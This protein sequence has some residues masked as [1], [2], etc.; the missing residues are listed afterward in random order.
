LILPQQ[1]HWIRHPSVSR[2]T[3]EPAT[4]RSI[5]NKIEAAEPRWPKVHPALKPRSLA[6]PIS[7]AT[8][9][10]VINFELGEIVRAAQGHNF[11]GFRLIFQTGTALD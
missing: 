2:R 5:K 10:V 8:D 6:A 9:S 4:T 11:P 3:Q 7:S 1:E